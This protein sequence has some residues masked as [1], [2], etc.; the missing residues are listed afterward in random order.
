MLHLKLPTD[1]R[2]VTMVKQHESEILSDHAW[3]E[4]KAAST[5]ISFIVKYHNFPEIVREMTELAA[6]EIQHFKHV[7]QFIE[8]R[9]YTLEPERKDPYVNRLLDFIQ[10]GGNPIGLLID[11]LLMAALIE[12][13]S[14]ERFRVLSESIQDPELKTFYRNLMASEA[15]H[16][17]MF[18]TLARKMNTREIVDRRW[19]EWLDFEA[20]IIHSFS[21]GR[22]IHT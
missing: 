8:Q 22:G 16:Y 17:T 20:E 11:K 9:G 12:A 2:W 7:I 6:E 10:K 19:Q 14:C 1:P 5:A 21:S 18:I 13:R 3:C 15:G 4:Q